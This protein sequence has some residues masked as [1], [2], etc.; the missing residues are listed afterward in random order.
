[1]QHIVVKYKAR[2]I[3]AMSSL[4]QMQRTVVRVIL[5]VSYWPPFPGPP[6]SEPLP[7]QLGAYTPSDNTFEALDKH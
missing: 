6:P 1:M 7:G 3:S 4:G 5:Q 2:P